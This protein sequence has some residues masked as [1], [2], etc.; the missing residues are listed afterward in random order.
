[1]LQSANNTK[2]LPKLISCGGILDRVERMTKLQ[3]HTE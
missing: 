3:T 2:V 1:M